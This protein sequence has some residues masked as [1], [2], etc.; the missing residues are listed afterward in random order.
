MRN[1]IVWRLGLIFCLLFFYSDMGFAEEKK[2]T[3]LEIMKRVDEANMTMDQTSTV[4]M[5]LIDELGSRRKV[6]TYRL[7]KHY[8]GKDGFDS[9]SIFFTEFPPDAKGIGFL[10]WDYAIEEKPDDLWLYLPALRSVRRMTTRGQHDAFM[11]SDLTFADMG[12]RRLDEDDHHIFFDG[13]CRQ[14]KEPC[15]VIESVPKEQDSP[16]GKKR[17]FISKKDE[18]ARKIEFYDRNM[19]PLK[20]QLI[21]W[22]RI[23][24]ILVWKRSEIINVQTRHRTIFEI[25]GV[26]INAGLRD[27]LFTDRTLVR[28]KPS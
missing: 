17:F 10:I 19:N 7:H 6:E 9:K 8:G 21:I 25:S 5:H 2:L 11:G 23:E 26:K 27:A 12:D 22:Q 16:Y 24:D 13:M 3:A 15:Y 4:T 1:S 28:G 18:I 20:I 14:L